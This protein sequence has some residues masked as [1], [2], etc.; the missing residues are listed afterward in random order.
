MTRIG[1]NLFSGE[2]MQVSAIYHGETLPSGTTAY[3]KVTTEGEPV[4][5]VS[6][7]VKEKIEIDNKP[8]G[9]TVTKVTPYSA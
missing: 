9:M 5:P 8:A 4:K 7:E 3:L 1:E 2:K 6:E